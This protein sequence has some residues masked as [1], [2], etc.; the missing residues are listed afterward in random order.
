M[1]KT[2]RKTSKRRGGSWSRSL[3]NRGLLAV[4][5][6]ADMARTAANDPNN[7]ARLNNLRS[8]ASAY[9]NRALD[10]IDSGV[11][12]VKAAANDPNNIA[13]LNNLRS[14]ASAYGNRALDAIDSGVSG[15]SQMYQQNVSPERRAQI[16]ALGQQGQQMAAQGLQQGRQMAAQGLNYA[17]K[18]AECV[19]RCSSGVGGRRKRKLK[20]RKNKR[21]SR[22]NKRKT[23]RY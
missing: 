14:Q 23:R 5:S 16:S 20:S 11:D 9:G 10:A 22:K 13:R 12:R 18:Q 8:Q 7:I 3:V 19:R 17:Q 2:K 15:A 6:A 21:K 4:N 1:A